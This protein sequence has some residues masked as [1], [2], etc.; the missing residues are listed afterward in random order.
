MREN[1]EDGRGSHS[2]EFPVP[3]GEVSQLMM[4]CM[5]GGKRHREV[6]YSAFPS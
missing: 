3:A 1:S 6:L 4:S 5:V 2:A